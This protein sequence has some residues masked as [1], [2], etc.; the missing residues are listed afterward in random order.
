MFDFYCV[1]LHGFF[2]KLFFS[3]I[4]C[5]LTLESMICVAPY[6]MERI[7]EDISS[8]YNFVTCRGNNSFLAKYTKYLGE[9]S[10]FINDISH[11]NECNKKGLSLC[12]T[13]LKI[14]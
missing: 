12:F 3:L 8:K 2:L 7:T 11:S 5:S 9:E 1:I 13:Y 4:L 6:E 14:F 10:E